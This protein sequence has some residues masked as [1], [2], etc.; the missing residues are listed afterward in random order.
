DIK[1]IFREFF[2]E[3]F[4]HF[5]AVD[6]TRR[7]KS[8]GTDGFSFA[9][10]KKYWDILK[11]DI[12]AYVREF[13]ENG[14]IPSGDPLS[15][16]LFILLMEA[17]HVAFEDAIN[18]GLYRGVQ[19]RSLH[20]SHLLFVDA[21]LFL[22]E[23]S[24]SNIIRLVS[25]LQCFHDVSGL[26]INLHKSNLYGIG[27]NTHEISNLA[28]FTGCT[29]QRLPFTYLGIPIGS[30]MSRN[31]EWNPIIDKFKK[32]LSKWKANMLSIG[33]RSTLITS[34]LGS[35]GVYYLSLFPIHKLINKRLESLQA[36]FFRGCT[37]GIKKIPWI[38]WNSVLASKV[39]G[40]LSIGSG[41]WSRIVGT[42]NT[43]HDK[44]TIPHS[45]IKRQVKDGSS[46]RFWRDAW[47][48]D[49]PL[50]RKFPRLFCLE[51]NKDCLVRDKWQNG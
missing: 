5:E 18:V 7:K 11:T 29:P 10:Y 27:V 34:V 20:I 47:L 50:E 40:G 14:N 49:I 24:R 45:S 15:P 4:K 23:W 17:L 38:A 28:S 12:M 22:G 21:I 1:D 30:N 33:G 9:F 35:F 19:V 26:K 41:T 16:F 42:I 36:N 8:P 13:F 51:A 37:D 6:V 46:T 43:M 31:K 32:R 39:K 44:G 3:K 2:V 48:G 25:L